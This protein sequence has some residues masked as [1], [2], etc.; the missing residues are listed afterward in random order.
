M[1]APP[2]AGRKAPECGFL[3]SCRL[4][5]ARNH[6][7]SAIPDSPAKNAA[8]AAAKLSDSAAEIKDSATRQLESAERRTELAATRN[9]L[10]AE[11]TYTA[12]VRT[13]IAALAA[14][15]GAKPL[16]AGVVPAWLGS[17]TGTALLL[18]SGWCFVAALW[19]IWDP[20]VPPPAPDIR[21]LRRMFVLGMNGFLLL[22]T[23]AAL[24]G[25]WVVRV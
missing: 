11:R 5:S 1:V 23:L 19:R 4:S 18:F 7:D 8:K 2:R 9:V 17:V 6:G 14:G 22:V 10:A 15:V 12:W 24:V 13:G 16:L 3:H 20:G 25:V 21:P